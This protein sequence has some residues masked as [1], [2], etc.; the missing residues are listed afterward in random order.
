MAPSGVDRE[1]LSLIQKGVPGHFPEQVLE[2]KS[3]GF[4]PFLGSENRAEYGLRAR[5][6]NG[7]YPSTEISCLPEL[8][9]N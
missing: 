5:T 8:I 3:A 9:E 6:G 7:Q 1:G 2:L 4:S